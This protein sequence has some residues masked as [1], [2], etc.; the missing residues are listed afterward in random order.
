MLRQSETVRIDDRCFFVMRFK[1]RDVFVSRL[2]PVRPEKQVC[3]V[4]S[5]SRSDN[6]ISATCHFRT[7]RDPLDQ[8]QEEPRQHDDGAAV[9]KLPAASVAVAPER[10]R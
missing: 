2:D 7:P 10:R 9:G 6:P 8:E 1:V 5:L 3:G 4:S